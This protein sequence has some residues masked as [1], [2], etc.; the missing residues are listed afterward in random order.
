MVSGASQLV[1]ACFPAVRWKIGSNLLMGNEYYLL[2]L[3]VVRRWQTNGVKIEV[4]SNVPF[5][6]VLKSVGRFGE[7]S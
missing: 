1:G 7:N 2:R 4:A 6:P 5:E 3:N